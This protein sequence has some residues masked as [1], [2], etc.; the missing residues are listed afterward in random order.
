ME[1]TATITQAIFEAIDDLNETLELG[2]PVA[3][4]ENTV[5]FGVG[6]QLESLHLVTL[7]TAI[8]ENIERCGL[9]EINLMDLLPTDDRPVT[10]TSLARTI[11][12][13]KAARH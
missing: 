9:G 1:Q 7:L 3:K 11:A 10:V 5:I 6:T 13:S 12:E 4:S 8:E 2:R